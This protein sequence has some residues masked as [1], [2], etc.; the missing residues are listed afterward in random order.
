[1]LKHFVIAI[2]TFLFFASVS[3]AGDFYSAFQGQVQNFWQNLQQTAQTAFSFSLPK[4]DPLLAVKKAYLG[5]K[6]LVFTLWTFEDGEDAFFWPLQDFHRKYPHIEVKIRTFPT[7]E[8]Y[9]HELSA[10]RN[11]GNLPDIFLVSDSELRLYWNSLSPAP[12]EFFTLETLKNDFF[13]LAAAAFATKTKT[14]A[15]PLYLYSEAM[16]YNPA[17]LRDDRIAIGDK[18][19]NTW[20]EMAEIRRNYAAYGDKK[21]AFLSI[22]PTTATKNLFLLLL[23]QSGAE[24]GLKNNAKA[25]DALE[26]LTTAANPLSL[27]EK[28]DLEAFKARR[29]AIIFGDERLAKE[30][31][32]LPSDFPVGQMSVPQLNTKNPLTLGEARG[33]AVSAKSINVNGA[34]VLLDFLTNEKNTANFVLKTGKTPLRK[35]LAEGFFGENAAKAASAS[36]YNIFDFGAIFATEF[37]TF[38]SAKKTAQETLS[39]FDNFFATQK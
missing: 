22:T 18:P 25:L 5:D 23:L 8:I 19:A 31:N 2:G 1:M 28:S 15:A 36:T 34:W 29:L 30:L 17:L 3:A 13:P 21:T 35:T 9:W 20:A 10:A 26:F 14:W 38:L 33:F 24:S 6:P 16:F 32:K 37:R 4:S 39:A 7:E 12:K 11:H 27:K